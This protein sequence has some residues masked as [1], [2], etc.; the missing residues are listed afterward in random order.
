MYAQ[1]FSSLF[2][3]ESEIEGWIDTW[4]ELDCDAESVQ[5]ALKQLPVQFPDW[6]PTLGQFKALLTNQPKPY[7]ALPPP[8]KTQPSAEQAAALERVAT[9]KLNPRMPWWT[10][11]KV[12]NQQ[13]VDVIVMQARHFG[14]GSDAG[15]FL[16][17]CQDSGV[18]NGMELA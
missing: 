14:A 11:D 9:A 3:D 1:K 16:R 6:P 15:Q 10:P 8:V 12:K 7:V 4:A 13:Q 5:A 2:K 17:K 18:I